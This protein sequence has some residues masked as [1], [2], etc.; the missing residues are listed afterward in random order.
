MTARPARRSDADRLVSRAQRRRTLATT[1]ATVAMGIAI[2][3]AVPMTGPDAWLGAVGGVLA[4]ALVV[5]V[6]T[7][8]VQA[9]HRSYTPISDAVQAVT[10]I[11][12]L[13]VFGFAA[14]YVV[15]ADDP[16]QISG[17][18]TK[19][20]AVYFSMTTLSTVGYGDI[21]AQGQLARVAV[22]LQ[23]VFDLALIAAAFRLIGGMARDRAA[24]IGLELQRAEE[25]EAAAGTAPAEG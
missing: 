3:S 4:V 7:R 16:T 5:P 22:T 23:M 21:H 19:I 25:A 18:E 12:T 2:Y 8:R 1:L 6:T 10:L 24:A 15:M 9:I 20:D 17:L 14:A 13:L 11:T